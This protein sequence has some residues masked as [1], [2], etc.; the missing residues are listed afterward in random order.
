MA[1][2]LTYCDMSNNGL[3]HNICLGGI[4]NFFPI[5]FIYYLSKM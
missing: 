5:D 3:Q 1:G 4:K 2:Y